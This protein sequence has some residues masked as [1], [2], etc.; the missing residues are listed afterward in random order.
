MIRKKVENIITSDDFKAD[1]G[2]HGLSPGSS[3]LVPLP[4]VKQDFQNLVFFSTSFVVPLADDLGICVEYL[5]RNFESFG[6][7]LAEL[8]ETIGT[9][10]S[11]VSCSWSFSVMIL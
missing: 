4:F 11:V 3:G 1:L 7:P 9:G 2:G 6:S 5:S 8:D 10:A